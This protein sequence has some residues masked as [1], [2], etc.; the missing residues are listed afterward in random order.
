MIEPMMSAHCADFESGAIIM[1]NSAMNTEVS[2][3][4]FER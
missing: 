2:T 3:K 4:D 1:M